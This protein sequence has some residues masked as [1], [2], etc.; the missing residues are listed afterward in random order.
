MSRKGHIYPALHHPPPRPV[1]GAEQSHDGLLECTCQPSVPY[2]L[3]RC[4]ND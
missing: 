2:S 3:R 4:A 1:R